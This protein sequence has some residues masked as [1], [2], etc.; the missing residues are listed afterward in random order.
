MNDDVE[1]TC[2][3]FSLALPEGVNRADLPA[4]LENFAAAVRRTKI[5]SVLD[6]TFDSEIEDDG[7]E[8]YS[9][10]IYYK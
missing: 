5:E 3:M 1:Y 2:K 9:L 4:L 6:V 10:T 8:T 7:L